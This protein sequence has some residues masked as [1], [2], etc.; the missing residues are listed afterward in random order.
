VK[1]KD[2]SPLTRLKGRGCGGFYKHV[3]PTALANSKLHLRGKRSATLSSY[4][5][6]HLKV[7]SLDNPRYQVS[8]PP[9]KCQSE[10][11]ESPGSFAAS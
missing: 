4:E 5:V 11:D 2:M 1:A 10:T 8:N 7:M 6:S 9:V 3:A